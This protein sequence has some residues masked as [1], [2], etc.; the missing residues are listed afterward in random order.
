[1]KDLSCGAGYYLSPVTKFSTNVRP[2]DQVAVN[3][4]YKVFALMDPF[5]GV[6]RIWESESLDSVLVVPARSALL[7]PVMQFTAPS[8][9][10]GVSRRL[11]SCVWS[12]DGKILYVVHMDGAITLMQARQ[13]CF[14]FLA[15][16]QALLSTH[17]INDY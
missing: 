3:S 9:G 14:V 4:I 13:L 11:A 7:P 2:P 12:M 5:A 1:V 16:T 10:A 6:V 17:F 15:C 8:P